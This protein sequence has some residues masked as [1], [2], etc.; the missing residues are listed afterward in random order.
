MRNGSLLQ[1]WAV[2]RHHVGVPGKHDARPVG[3]PDRCVEIGL[4]FVAVVYDR[5]VDA[6]PGQVVADEMDEIE[7]GLAARR[8]E[9]DERFHEFAGP[10]G[11]DGHAG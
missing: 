6:E 1:S 7:V 3:W 11:G 2:D 10:G 9:A 8:V 4:G 5:A